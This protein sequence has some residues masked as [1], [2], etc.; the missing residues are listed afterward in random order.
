MATSTIEKTEALSVVVAKLEEA[1]EIIRKETGAPRATLVIARDTKNKAGHFTQLEAW[2]NGEQGFHE[3]LISA[4]WFK[5]GAEFVLDTLIHETAHSINFQSN[6]KDCTREGYHNKDFKKTA[7]A[8][9]LKAEKS[10]R[11]GF[12]Q[13][14]LTPEGKERWAE[15]LSI[16]EEAIKLVAIPTANKPKGRNKNL[17]VASCPECGEKIRLSQKSFEKC[18]PICGECL[19]DFKMAGTEEEGEE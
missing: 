1:H 2:N 9:G 18:K 12:N 3:I 7:E 4:D 5:N 10:K 11:G 14:S 16:V 17:G 19:V 6:I 15:A 13:T 8:L